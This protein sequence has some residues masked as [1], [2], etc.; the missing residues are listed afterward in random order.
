MANLL[1]EDDKFTF[2]IVGPVE[3]SLYSYNIRNVDFKKSNDRLSQEQY[4]AEIESIDYA[5]SF[6]DSHSIMALA[7]GSFFDCI[8]FAKPILAISGN[9]FVDYYFEVLGDIGFRFLSVI[10]MAEY[11]KSSQFLSDYHITY[12][13]QVNALLHAQETLSIANITKQFAKQL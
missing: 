12:E 10:D 13:R 7:S 5:V 8:K 2:K 4:Y 3:P 11:I 6:Y 1:S 9:S